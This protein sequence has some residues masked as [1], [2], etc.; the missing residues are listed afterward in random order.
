MQLKAQS[1]EEDLEAAIISAIITLDI[2]NDE[3]A[4]LCKKTIKKGDEMRISYIDETES[5]KERQIQLKDYGF[6]CNCKKCEK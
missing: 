6:I 5:F 3:V 4:F 1:S 2:D